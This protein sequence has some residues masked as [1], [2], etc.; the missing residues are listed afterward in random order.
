MIKTIL[1]EDELNA[2]AGLHKMLKILSP[3]IKI[4]GETGF[5][6]EAVRLIKIEKPDL[7][8]M[9]VELENGTGF[10][11]L[12]Q[13][14]T[15]DFKI[16]F[17]TAF[18][19]YAINAFKFSAIDYLLKPINP[20]ELEDAIKRSISSITNDKEHK[21][22]IAVLKNNI[23]KKEQKIVLKTTEQR[24]VIFVKDIIHLEADGA[25]TNFITTTKKIIVSKNIKYYQ[26][27]LGDSFIRCHQSHLINSTHIMGIDKNGFLQVSNNDLIPISTRKKTEILQLMHKL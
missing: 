17:T 24:H 6:N 7:V 16:I 27:L 21:K 9:D 18:S 14:S 8:F 20:T 12:K 26:D 3:T 1:I 4:I 15:I 25:Y 23:E 13:L 10:D 2:R 5:V 22:L 11:I 19:Q